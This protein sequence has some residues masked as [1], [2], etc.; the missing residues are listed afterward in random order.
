MLD[1]CPLLT[2]DLFEPAV[3]AVEQAL[4]VTIGDLRLRGGD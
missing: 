1:P 4:N 2:D 3:R